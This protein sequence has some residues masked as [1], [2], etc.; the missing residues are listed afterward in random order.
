MKEKKKYKQNE[1]MP[2]Q[3]GGKRENAGRKPVKPELKKGK[4]VVIRVEEKLL[5]E[6]EKLK[7]G[8][9]AQKEQNE[10]LK[11]EMIKQI[12]KIMIWQQEAE[13]LEGKRKGDDYGQFEK[14]INMEIGL[15]ELK[16]MIESI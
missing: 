16:K 2:L 8:E 12:E 10:K 9:T 14:I 4:T 3:H 5:P 15:H 11:T 13:A 6:I 7:N 1:L